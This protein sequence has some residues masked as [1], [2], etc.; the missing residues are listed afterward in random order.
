MSAMGSQI[1][2]LTIV[3][4]TV[5]SGAD[6]RKRAG[7]SPV[8]GEFTAKRASYV[9]NI[10]IWWRHHVQTSS[11]VFTSQ[12]SAAPSAHMSKM[13][14]VM[15][16]RR[17]DAIIRNNFSLT[18]TYVSPCLSSSMQMNCL[19]LNKRILFHKHTRSKMEYCIMIS[20]ERLGVKKIQFRIY[21][22]YI[23]SSTF[24]NCFLINRRLLSVYTFKLL[25]W[26]WLSYNGLW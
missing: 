13:G 21:C 10:S 24:N 26:S 7:N 23:A 16:W 22:G 3:Y 8:T 17:A 20:T 1:T 2:S 18:I 11:I 15:L 12:F 25:R 14:Y 5:Y 4:S 6:Q 19:G 9:E